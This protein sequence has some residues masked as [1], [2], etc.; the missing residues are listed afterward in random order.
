VADISKFQ[1]KFKAQHDLLE[2]AVAQTERQ[3]REFTES[4]ARLQADSS[5]ARFIQTRANIERQLISIPSAIEQLRRATLP[6]P[7]FHRLQCELDSSLRLSQA[8]RESIEKF[9]LSSLTAADDVTTRTMRDMQKIGAVG[10][11]APINAAIE[12]LEANRASFERFFSQ[13]NQLSFK[14]PFPDALGF[15]QATQTA[16]ERAAAHA[17]HIQRAIITATDQLRITSRLPGLLEVNP[18]G[19]I[20][21]GGESASA[22]EVSEAVEGLFS[23][24]REPEFFESLRERLKAFKSP[25]QAVILWVLEKVLLVIFLS[26]ISDMLSPYVQSY[27][28]QFSFKSRREVTQAIKRLPSAI[29]MDGFKGFRVVTGDRLRLREKPS[30]EAKVLDELNR[31][32]L[33]R[34]IEKRR[35]WTL[36]EVMYQDSND[37]LQGWV[38]TRYIAVIRR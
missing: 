9:L 13:L 22:L 35:N 38:A 19:T 15:N 11:K 32:K 29:E 1:E 28:N 31:G 10:V 18:E 12:T 5:T 17:A 2:G 27:F 3:R 36:V 4:I 8:A 14:I 25:I 23:L 6:L 33:V 34:V 37:V 21:L 16:I 24:I 30:M 20:T 7:D 26:I